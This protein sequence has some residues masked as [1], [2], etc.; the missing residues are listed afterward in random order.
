MPLGNYTRENWWAG[1]NAVGAGLC[2][3]YIRYMDGSSE[4]MDLAMC[5]AFTANIV[6]SIQNAVRHV[7]REREALKESSQ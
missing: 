7:M 6:L 3:F 5:V 2:L 4:E 1:I